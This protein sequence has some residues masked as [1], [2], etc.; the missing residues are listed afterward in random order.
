MRFDNYENQNLKTMITLKINIIDIFLKQCLSTKRCSFFMFQ[1]L[2]DLHNKK[3][4]FDTIWT[5]CNKMKL[6]NIK[7]I[8]R[9][10]FVLFLLYKYSYLQI[11]ISS[12]PLTELL[13]CTLTVITSSNGKRKVLRQ[14]VIEDTWHPILSYHS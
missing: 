14:E 7:K 4:L 12:I 6:T 13:A 1:I 8:W 5:I 3:S 9:C 11:E 2:L 10:R